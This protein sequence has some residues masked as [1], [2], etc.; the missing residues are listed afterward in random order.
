MRIDEKVKKI[1]LNIYKRMNYEAVQIGQVCDALLLRVGHIDQEIISLL[2]YEIDPDK[3]DA[4][5]S[6][7]QKQL[8]ALVNNPQ[9]YTDE[10]WQKNTICISIDGIHP[11]VMKEILEGLSK[12]DP[13]RKK[14]GD[15]IADGR[16]FDIRYEYISSK[17]WV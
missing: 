3:F 2:F 15:R 7:Q 14:I 8:L 11:H 4:C 17:F 9:R 5:S 16:I 1:I 12:I 13:E 6:S 10:L